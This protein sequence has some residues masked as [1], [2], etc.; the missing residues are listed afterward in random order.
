MCGCPTGDCCIANSCD[1]SSHQAPTEALADIRA[2][3]KTILII[4]REAS[5]GRMEGEK[6]EIEEKEKEGVKKKNP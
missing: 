1:D 6:E 4:I 2:R 3:A 5:E